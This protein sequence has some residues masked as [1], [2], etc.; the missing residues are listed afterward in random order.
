M[1]WKNLWQNVNSAENF[2]K[3]LIKI[4]LMTRENMNSIEIVVEMKKLFVINEKKISFV[5]INF[6]GNEWS[7]ID[8][9]NSL[10]KIVND[11]YKWFKKTNIT[12]LS[13][14]S[15]FMKWTNNPKL[16]SSFTT[17]KQIIY[18]KFENRCAEVRMWKIKDKKSKVHQIFIHVRT[19]ENTYWEIDFMNRDWWKANLIFIFKI[20]VSRQM[21][22][23]FKAP[24][25]NY[26]NEWYIKQCWRRYVKNL[27]DNCWIELWKD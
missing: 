18:L 23:I 27:K 1:K 6:K 5:M 26:I 11:K 24:N 4:S 15:T 7:N 20:R 3:S 16:L 17:L 22:K 9:N 8:L 21:Q 25:N 2:N 13:L 14:N 10:N 19:K 12:I